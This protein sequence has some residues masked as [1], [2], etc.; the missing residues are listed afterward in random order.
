M[1]VFYSIEETQR[2]LGD[3]RSKIYDLM[4][5]GILDCRKDGRRIK[6]TAASI[7]RRAKT[8]PRATL[9]IYRKGPTA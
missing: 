9:K 8:L 5:E 2:I 3:S 1:P 7:R 6:I 4:A